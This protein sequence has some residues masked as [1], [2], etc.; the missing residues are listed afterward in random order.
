FSLAYIWL[1]NR[2]QTSRQHEIQILFDDIGGLEVGDKIIF[3]GM[4][5]GRIKKVTIEQD[6]ILVTGRIEN[7]VRLFNEARFYVSESSLM[8]GK[9]LVIETGVSDTLL[10]LTKIHRGSSR[11]GIMAVITS[12]AQAIDEFRSILA[13]IS[14]ENGVIPK[15][16]EFIDSA[17][18]TMQTTD[19]KLDML[20]KELN[21]SIILANNT[22]EQINH[23]VSEIQPDLISSAAKAPPLLDKT[24]AALDS[25][26][27]VIS[28]LNQ[29]LSEINDGSGTAAK[30]LNEDQLYN[31][32]LQTV[33]SLEILLKDI[34]ANPRKYIKMSVF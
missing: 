25:L 23:L 15:T 8:G 3:K 28:G 34:K 7:S 32:M 27:Q 13:Q 2:F 30:L 33:D 21:K 29:S 14:R 24:N 11:P 18:K 4:E 6:G 9:H 31:R 20:H 1:T 26:V 19:D 16:E 5:A 10:D 12:G 22:I 17:N